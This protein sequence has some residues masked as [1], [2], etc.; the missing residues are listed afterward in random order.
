M[1]HLDLI[2]DACIKANPEIEG[3]HLFEV[4]AFRCKFCKVERIVHDRKISNR[5]VDE[6]TGGSSQDVETTDYNMEGGP[7]PEHS[8]RPIRLADVL[9]AIGRQRADIAV[10]YCGE[11]L[12]NSAQV[13]YDKNDL[14]PWQFQRVF[15]NIR[16]DNLE[17]QSPKTL[18]FLAELLK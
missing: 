4:G 11:F 2:R 14:Y 8:S 13:V 5:I 15:W 16:K 3:K 6:G 7:C 18:A 12:K 17:E 9:L 1:T 10:T